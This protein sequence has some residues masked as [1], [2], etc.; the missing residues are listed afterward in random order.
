MESAA[1]FTVAWLLFVVFYLL[2]AIGPT[3]LQWMDHIPYQLFP[4]C[5]ALLV[6]TLINIYIFYFILFVLI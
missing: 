2:S 5:L 1:M 3:P 4:G 6:R